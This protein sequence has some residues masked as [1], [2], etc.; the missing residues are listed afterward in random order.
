MSNK[1][2][3][4]SLLPIEKFDYK[5]GYSIGLDTVSVTYVNGGDCIDSEPQELVIKTENNG[6]ARFIVLETNRWAISDIN[7]IIE[8]LSDFKRRAEL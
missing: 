7:E 5:D 1:D 3:S 6:V 2:K 8:V 4:F